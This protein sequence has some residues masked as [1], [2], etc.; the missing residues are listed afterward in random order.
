MS[1]Y[2]VDPGVMNM[3]GEP[4]HRLDAV[5]Q[6]L[7]I[8]KTRESKTHEGA[9]QRQYK[10]GIT[11]L[12]NTWPKTRLLTNKTANTRCSSETRYSQVDSH[13]VTKIYNEPAQD[14]KHKGIIK[15]ETNEGNRWNRLGNNDSMRIT[16]GWGLKRDNISTW[17]KRQAMRLHTNHGSAMILPQNKKNQWHDGRIW[18]EGFQTLLKGTL[19]TGHDRLW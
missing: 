19:N 3:E 1:P 7:I 8:Q 10:R 17:P 4:K 5:T 9:K 14:S 12:D 15:G 6:R 11:K 13:K 2:L 16:R 18:H